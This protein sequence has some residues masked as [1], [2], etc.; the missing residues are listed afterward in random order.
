MTSVL[1]IQY[2]KKQVG[3]SNPPLKLEEFKP[4]EPSRCR[5][6]VHLSYKYQL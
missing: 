2:F 5:I 4:I 3:G 1:K 6:K